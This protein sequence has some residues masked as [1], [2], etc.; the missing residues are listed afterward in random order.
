MT[1]P[2]E[3]DRTMATSAL[4]CLDSVPTSDDT[5]ED[6]EIAGTARI[7]TLPSGLE[8]FRLTPEDGPGLLRLI[9]AGGDYSEI[10]FGTAPSHALSQFVRGP[11]TVPAESKL[12]L[13]VRVDEE[14]IL[15]ANAVLGYPNAETVVVDLLLID[16]RY[17][18]RGFGGEFI[19]TL[20][21]WA[22]GQGARRI[23][24]DCHITENRKA[25][26]FWSRLGFTESARF[27][28]LPSPAGPRTRVL[29]SSPLPLRSGFRAV[30]RS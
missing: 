3:R 24:V 9:E 4:T 20:G 5:T 26:S 6:P 21:E 8:V 28:E 15:G 27:A 10:G 29:L 23:R 11:D 25:S 13:G 2:S 7:F 30:R 19:R 12:P 22:H 17:R 18:G 1:I 14:V 16:P